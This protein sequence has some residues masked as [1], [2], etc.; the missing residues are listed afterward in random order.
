[1][2]ILNKNEHSIIQEKL[3]HF[4]ISKSKTKVIS[5][6]F[7]DVYKYLNI[8][9][10]SLFFIKQS[11]SKQASA[12]TKFAEN[13]ACHLPSIT[14]SG[15]GDMEYYLTSYNVGELFDLSQ[16]E[17]NPEYIANRILKKIE[18]WEYPAPEFEK[19]F[20]EHFNK[21]N[22]VEKYSKIYSWLISK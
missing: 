16:L 6:S 17:N 3:N 13:V 2:L 12:P 10:A 18:K 14:N 9:N 11:Y 5:S 15:V 1:L 21:D 19:L 7:T 22:A 8:A 4:N 20:N